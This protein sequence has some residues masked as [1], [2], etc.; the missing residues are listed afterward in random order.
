MDTPEVT[1][2]SLWRSIL[3]NAELIQE[4]GNAAAFIVLDRI[5][6]A[7]NL[8][9][10]KCVRNFAWRVSFEERSNNATVKQELT[11]KNEKLLITRT[12]IILEREDH[13]IDLR[14]WSRLVK[15]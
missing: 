13:L 15:D 6:L 5:T 9:L 3:Q 8:A 12:D 7:E 11:L 14:S 1:D 4:L 10:F 2:W